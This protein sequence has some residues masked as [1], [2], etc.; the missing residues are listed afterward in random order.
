M[1]DRRFSRPRHAWHR[2]GLGIQ[3]VG[4]GR[5]PPCQLRRHTLRRPGRSIGRCLLSPNVYRAALSDHART[6]ILASTAKRKRSR[7][8]S[9]LQAIASCDEKML[10]SQWQFTR[11]EEIND[12]RDG[13]GSRR[14]AALQRTGALGNKRLK[15]TA[16][17][18]TLYP[19]PVFLGRS[20]VKS[21][22]RPPL[23]RRDRFHTSAA[24]AFSIRP[25]ALSE[26]TT[27]AK[28]SAGAVVSRW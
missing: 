9:L 11:S 14:T 1:P 18:R 7:G 16:Y 4:Q 26:P 2:R 23:E 20:A 5:Y 22:N 12:V 13:S 10:S 28:E 6:H 21:L 17:R 8:L 27:A 19:P 25:F 15:P 3:S 24:I